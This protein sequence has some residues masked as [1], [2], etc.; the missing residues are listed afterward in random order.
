MATPDMQQTERYH[1]IAVN[2]VFDLVFRS[3]FPNDSSRE[4]ASSGHKA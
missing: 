1:R 4:A 2:E 3:I